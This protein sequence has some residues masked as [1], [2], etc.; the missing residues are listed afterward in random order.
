MALHT[1]LPIHRTGVSLL[2]LAIK[3]QEQMPRSVKRSLGDKITE[4]CVA[5][6]DLMA[7]ANAS[8]HQERAARIQD[9]LTRQRAVSVLLRV[10]LD[11]RYTS[12]KL[13]AQCG[14]CSSCTASLAGC[15]SFTAGGRQAC[16]RRR[17]RPSRRRSFCAYW[18]GRWWSQQELPRKGRT[19]T[20]WD[21]A[22][23]R[24]E[25]QPAPTTLL[26][27]A[28]DALETS[29]DRELGITKNKAGVIVSVTVQ[30]KDGRIINVLAESAAC[31]VREPLTPPHMLQIGRKHFGHPTPQAWFDAAR[32]LEQA[33]GIGGGGNG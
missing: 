15:G 14:A 7:L 26:Q 9:L 30:D 21:L 2:A 17:S 29:C 6:L 28:L 5:M 27:Q 22:Y 20:E 32:E 33:H 19:M 3:V 12:P 13:W 10:S 16:R 18:G 25:V 23:M 31:A 1:Q 24:R 4:H 8:Q 11:S